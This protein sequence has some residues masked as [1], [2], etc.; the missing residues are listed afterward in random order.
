MSYAYYVGERVLQYAHNAEG[1]FT[2]DSGY[3]GDV[4]SLIWIA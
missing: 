3:P 1:V 4:E 2:S